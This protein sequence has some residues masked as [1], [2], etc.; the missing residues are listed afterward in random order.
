MAGSGGEIVDGFVAPW[1]GKVVNE[2]NGVEAAVGDTETPDEV[3][4]VRNVLLM[5]F[6]GEDNH[7]KPAG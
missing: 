4:D 2:G 5:R 7:G 6:G 3:S 1:N